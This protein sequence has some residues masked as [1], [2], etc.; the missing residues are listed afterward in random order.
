[1]GRC[2]DRGEVRD[3]GV[4][5]LR[6]V[7]QADPSTP[8]LIYCGSRAAGTY[9]DTALAK[10]ADLITASPAVLTQK[11]QSLGLL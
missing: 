11:L 6:E 8:F 2:E 3:A 4:K 9:Q 10:G 7:R 5:L 1:M